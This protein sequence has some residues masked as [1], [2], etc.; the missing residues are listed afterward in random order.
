MIKSCYQW[1]EAGQNYILVTIVAVAGSSPRESG[2]RL[3]VSAQNTA[4]TIG[5]GW[6]EW[7]AIL[8]ARNM[9]LKDQSELMKTIILGPETGQ[10]CGGKVTLH[11]RRGNPELLSEI[12]QTEATLKAQEPIVHIYGAGHVGRALAE[13]LSPLPL[14]VTLID[15]REG[16]IAQCQAAAVQKELTNTPVAFAENAPNGSAHVIMTHDHALDAQIAGAVL[17]KGDFRYLGII[18]SETKRARFL[19]AFGEV[20]YA[21]SLIDRITCPIGGKDIADKRPEVIAALTATEI[22][23]AV[24]S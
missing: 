22:I 18:G 17:E 10:C 16:E 3:A 24:L 11:F 2:A 9:L 1:Q 19:K 23:K 6:L 12:A 15:S 20:G 13:A 4:G 21:Q 8:V 14:Q 7:D 5:G